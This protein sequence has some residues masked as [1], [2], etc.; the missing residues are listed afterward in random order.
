ML[1]GKKKK[2]VKGDGMIDVGRL[3]QRGRVLGPD[4]ASPQLDTDK[5]GFAVVGNDSSAQPSASSA[6]AAGSESVLQSS[7]FMDMTAPAAQPSTSFSTE[8]DGYSKREVDSKVQELDRLIYKLEQRLEVL[9][10]KAGVDPGVSSMGSPG[11]SSNNN[12]IIGW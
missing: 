3:Q 7:S 6:P 2:K 10:K 5:D 11:A 12:G 8:K 1:F 9:E 4:T